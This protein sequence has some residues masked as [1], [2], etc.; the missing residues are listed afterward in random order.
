MK[1]VAKLVMIDKD[2]NYLLMYRSDHPLFGRDADLPGGTLEEGESAAEAVIREVEEET[3]VV[4][5]DV[6][7]VY[8]G[9]EYSVHGTHKSLFVTR[10]VER[11]EIIMS[12]EHSAYEWIPKEEFLEKAKQAN[13]TYMHMVYAVLGP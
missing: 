3:G 2:D 11:P 4:V 5:E 7:K 1:K 9:L 10:V 8:A 6:D 12:W 13:D